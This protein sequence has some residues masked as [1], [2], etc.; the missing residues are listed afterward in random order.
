MLRVVAGDEETSRDSAF[1]ST[2]SVRDPP[3]PT[4]RSNWVLFSNKTRSGFV[5]PVGGTG[6][7]PESR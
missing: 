1:T 6:H 2:T 3:V 7:R 5:I 4:T